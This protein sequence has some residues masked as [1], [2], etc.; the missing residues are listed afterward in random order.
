MLRTRTKRKGVELFQEY[1]HAVTE[2]QL[3][4]VTPLDKCPES[5]QRA[6]RERKRRTKYNFGQPD[7][8]YA[9]SCNEVCGIQARHEALYVLQRHMEEAAAEAAAESESQAEAEEPSHEVEAFVIPPPPGL[10][11]LEGLTQ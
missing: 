5:L 6:Y 9:E 8:T 7:Y 3:A 1:G 4:N 10:P 2:E 11:G